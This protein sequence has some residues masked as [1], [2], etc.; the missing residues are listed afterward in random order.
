MINTPQCH[1]LHKQ[2]RHAYVHDVLLHQYTDK[3]GCVCITNGLFH[4]NIAKIDAQ[5]HTRTRTHAHTHTHMHTH[6][7]THTHMHT[8]TYANTHMHVAIHMR[9]WTHM[10]MHIAT[11]ADLY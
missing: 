2:P 5:M 6:T 7:H 10:H 1:K 3:E 8:Y 9:T 11:H 4:V